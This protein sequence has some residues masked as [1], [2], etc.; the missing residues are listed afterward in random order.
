LLKKCPDIERR[1][2]VTKDKILA[3]VHEGDENK[4]RIPKNKLTA[5]QT[6][7]RECLEN[8]LKTINV[9]G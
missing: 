6:K 7:I 2:H 3:H 8:N 9:K 5:G 4:M 1:S